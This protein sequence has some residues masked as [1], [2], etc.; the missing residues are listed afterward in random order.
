[1]LG[2]ALIVSRT[3]RGFSCLFPTKGPVKVTD[4]RIP[5]A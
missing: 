5:A 2:G 3:L 1:M 4:I